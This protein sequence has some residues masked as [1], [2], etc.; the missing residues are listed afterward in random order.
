[1]SVI[2]VVFHIKVGLYCTNCAFSHELTLNY[3][4]K[5]KKFKNKKLLEPQHEVF[6][7]TNNHFPELMQ[8]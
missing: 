1:M 5:M 8:R 6:M 2:L 4:F 3:F 7:N